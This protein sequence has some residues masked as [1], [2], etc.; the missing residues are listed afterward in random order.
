MK[1]YI[2]DSLPWTKHRQRTENMLPAENREP[3]IR[4]LILGGSR[5]SLRCSD[6][7]E[8][9]NLR[10]KIPNAEQPQWNDGGQRSSRCCIEANVSVGRVD[11]LSEPASEKGRRE[12]GKGRRVFH[13]QVLDEALW[14]T[15]TSELSL[16]LKTSSVDCFWLYWLLSLIYLLLTVRHS[17]LNSSSVIITIMSTCYF[18]YHYYYCQNTFT[19]RFISQVTHEVE[20]QSCSRNNVGGSSSS[21]SGSPS[22]PRSSRRKPALVSVL[23]RVQH[24]AMIWYAAPLVTSRSRLSVRFCTGGIIHGCSWQPL[25][26]WNKSK[27]KGKAHIL[28]PLNKYFLENTFLTP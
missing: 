5:S 25:A 18:Y 12:E 14:W 7:L 6:R 19:A 28:S 3:C 8:Q 1:G 27:G 21:G 9:K 24:T 26:C 11:C 16:V 23:W 4:N 13:F 22:F 10:L 17:V 20:L 15:R 2:S